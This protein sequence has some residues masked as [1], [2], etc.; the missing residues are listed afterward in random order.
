[1]T[2][3]YLRPAA[4]V[5]GAATVVAALAATA[6]ARQQT[7]TPQPEIKPIVR[8]I[9]APPD[10]A[11]PPDDAAKTRSGLATK[12]ITPGTG[13]DHPKS[14]DIVT[15]HY[16]GWSTKG[17]MFD[18][19]YTRGKPSTFQLNRVITGWGETVQLMVA[20]EK[21]RMWMSEDLASWIPCDPDAWTRAGSLFSINLQHPLLAAKPQCFFQLR[22]A[23]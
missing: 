16:T 18:S 17:A 6:G 20:G 4:F 22:P 1:M 11:A 13:A 21:R 9:P 23:D 12:V 8:P 15:V 14:D 10:V 3:S 5:I 19:S 2:F 7:P